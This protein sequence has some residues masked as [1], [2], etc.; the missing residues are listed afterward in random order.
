ML[1]TIVY[2]THQVEYDPAQ[3]LYLQLKDAEKIIVNSKSK[4]VPVFL[5]N[6]E[7]MV[8]SYLVAP[9]MVEVIPND[10][11]ESI[12]LKEKI[13]GILNQMRLFWVARQLALRNTMLECKMSDLKQTL[14]NIE[15]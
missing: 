5:E 7:A 15:G 3:S 8:A 11:I 12:E 14:C 1:V 2:P 6:L 9:V 10:T 13:D 4:D